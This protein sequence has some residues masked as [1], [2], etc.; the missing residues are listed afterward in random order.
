MSVYKLLWCAETLT[1]CNCGSER[2][3]DENEMVSSFDSCLNIV[4]AL[5]CPKESF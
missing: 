5:S 1:N 4:P 2:K 3:M